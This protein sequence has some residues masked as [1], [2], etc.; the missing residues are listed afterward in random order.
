MKPTFLIEGWL[1]RVWSLSLLAFWKHLSQDGN[2]PVGYVIVAVQPRYSETSA[3]FLIF[4]LLRWCSHRTR[5]SSVKWCVYF[6]RVLVM[7]GCNTESTDTLCE[8]CYA[9]CDRY[10]PFQPPPRALKRPCFDFPRCRCLWAAATFTSGVRMISC[11][12]ISQL[13][14]YK[15]G[16]FPTSATC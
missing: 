11:I 2:M 3:H 4:T 16:P 5:L 15:C 1:S 8:W 9:A 10:R 6:K 12:V 14:S 13:E 7:L